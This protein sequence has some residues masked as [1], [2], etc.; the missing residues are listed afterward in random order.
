MI[1]GLMLVFASIW[2]M[3]MFAQEQVLFELVGSEHSNIRFNNEIVDS[4]ERSILKYSNFYGGAGVGIADFDNDG[5]QDIFFAGNIVADKLYRNLGDLKFEDVTADAGIINDGSWSTSVVIGDVNNDALLDIYVTCELYDDQPNLRTNKLYINKGNFQFEEQADA[6]GLADQN[7]TRGATFIDYNR[8]GYLD[9]FLLNQ[10]PNPGNYSKYSGQALLRKEWSPRL[11]MNQDGKGFKDISEEAGVSIPC[12]PNSAVAA[13]INND[14]W[15]DL[16]VSNDYDAPDFLLINNKDGTFVNVIDQALGHMSYYSMGVDIADINNDG[17]LDIMTLD[18][19]AEDNY[20]QKANMGGMYPEVFWKLVNNGGH[21]QYM[22]NTL[23]LNYGNEHFGNIGQMAGVSNTDWSW[24]NVIADF[25]NDGLKDIYVTNGLL[26]DIRN[27]DVSKEFPEYV[28]SLADAYMKQHPDATQV[29]ILDIMDIDKA[30][31]MHPSVPLKNYAFRNKGDLTFEKSHD[32]W[33]MKEAAFSNGCAYG[34]LDNDGDLELVI[35]N[36]NQEAFLYENKSNSN[37]L[38]VDLS[39]DLGNQSTMGARVTIAYKGKKQYSELTRSRGMYSASEAMI[40][41]GVGDVDEV[42]SLIIRWPDGIS[43]LLTNVSTN[44][45]VKIRKGEAALS[46]QISIS[47]SDQFQYEVFSGSD[48]GIEYVHE[49]NLFDDYKRQVLLPH[50]LSEIGPALAV[51]DLNNDGLED[52][53][54]GGALGQAGACFIQ[55]DR[56]RFSK[57]DML[58]SDELIHEDVDAA[59]LDFDND[60]DLDLYVVSGGNEHAART[61]YYLDRLYENDGTGKLER[62]KTALPRILESG[63]CVRPFDYDQDGD[64]DLFIGGRHSPGDYPGPTI[65]RLLE[66]VEGQYTDVTKDKAK[67]FIWNGMVTDAVWVDYNRDGLTDLVAVGEWM[68]I[69][70]YK[71]SGSGLVED[72]TV[73]MLRD[74]SNV[75]TEGWWSHISTDDVNGD[76]WQD[77]LV[78][79]LG[80]NYKYKASQ[81]EPF[82]VF[83]GDFDE[84]GKKDIVLS[85]YNF[86]DRFPLRGRACSAEQ[87]PLIKADFPTYDLFA[88]AELTE[89]YSPSELE[90]S[91]HLTAHMFEH[92]VLYNK[93]GSSFDLIP[94]PNELQ[95]STI[96]EIVATENAT[97]EKVFSYGGNMYQSEIETPRNDA[98]I[99]GVFKIKNGALQVVPAE[100]SGI[101]L[102]YDVRHMK[103]IVIDGQR[104][105]IVV[106]NNDEV[107]IIKLMEQSQQEQND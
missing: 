58:D 44:Q 8:D 63:S 56:G 95:V 42:D 34:D 75:K 16:Y 59:F 67:D 69:T 70:F 86:G 38:R 66:N 37:F 22:F 1:R 5:L 32:A 17:W 2:T 82:E 101:H 4:K 13:D 80:K 41:F 93:G 100:Q 9:I 88:S 79:N 65:S 90:E 89:I 33:G 6:Y 71:N 94:L 73:D 78:G 62:N 104:C 107:R 55:D 25:D 11:L 21:Y 103:S 81:Q 97:G 50:K 84:S 74:G 24:S 26:R 27:S 15:Q 46:D 10:P 47:G 99:G 57:V 61:K 85:Y 31:D 29:P 72:D 43:E 92:V 64:V 77:L 14:G 87:I 3:Q 51:G 76:G 60:G 28:Q 23:Q 12:Y 102:P 52:M 53:Y 96:N 7:R 45:I 20:R 39:D 83:Y 49:E 91:L 36:I 40:H 98:S 18:M 68:P 105:T 30:L 48:V 106:S 54:I 19:V 35:N